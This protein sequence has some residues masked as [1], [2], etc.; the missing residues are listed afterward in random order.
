MTNLVLALDT[1]GD[2]PEDVSVGHISYAAPS[3]GSS[4]R[5]CSPISSGSTR[6]RPGSSPGCAII[7]EEIGI[8]ENVLSDLFRTS[9]P[10]ER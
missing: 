6:G 1:F 10:N 9:A 7:V 2:V 5:P 8:L 4:T 3:L